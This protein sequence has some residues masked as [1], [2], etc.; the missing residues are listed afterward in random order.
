VHLKRRI[1]IKARHL[2]SSCTSDLELLLAIGRATA[3]VA[4]VYIAHLCLLHT[5]PTP[6][7][8]ASFPFL[9]ALH[10]CGKDANLY[11]LHAGNPHK[12]HGT[13]LKANRCSLLTCIWGY[14]QPQKPPLTATP[15]FAPPHQ[16]G[17][18]LNVA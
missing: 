2:A 12:P 10:F 16:G 6:F 18:T 8:V 14:A 15:F 17:V 9:A 1:R 5:A 13:T 7:L 4:P 3:A 11:P